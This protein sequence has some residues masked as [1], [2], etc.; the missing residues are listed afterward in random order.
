MQ[1]T[2]TSVSSWGKYRDLVDVHVTLPI[3]VQIIVKNVMIL[4]LFR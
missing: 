1:E 4:I 3:F 2:W